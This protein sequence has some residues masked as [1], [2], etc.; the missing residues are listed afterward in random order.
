MSKAD[1]DMRFGLYSADLVQIFLHLVYRRIEAVIVK[2]GIVGADQSALSTH[3]VVTQLINEN[4][5]VQNAKLF[6]TVD[7]TA[8]IPINVLGKVCVVLHQTRSNQLFVSR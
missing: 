6:Q 5:V 8:C 2:Y 3:A 7:E 4:S 1:R